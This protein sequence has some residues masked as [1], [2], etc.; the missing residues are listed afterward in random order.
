MAY[1]LLHNYKLDYKFINTWWISSV[2]ADGRTLTRGL[3]HAPDDHTN[4]YATSLD[5]NGKFDLLGFKHNLLLGVDYFDED[6]KQSLYSGLAPA[7]YRTIDMFAPVYVPIAVQQQPT[8]WAKTKAKWYG[9]YIQDQISLSPEWKLLVG[10][11]WDKPETWSGSS[12]VSYEGADAAF[13]RTTKNSVFNPRVGVVYQPQ[14]WLSLYGNYVESMGAANTGTTASGAAFDPQM[15]QQ[16]EV[17]L[18]AELLEK[19]LLANVALFDLTKQNLKTTDPA[20][21][22]F[23]IAVGEVR[24]R[25]L[26]IDLT[27]NITNALSVVATYAHLGSEITKDNGGN[28]GKRLYNTPKNS[29]SLWGKYAFGGDLYGLSAGA[30]VV[31]VGDHYGNN[32]NTTVVPGYTRTDAMLAYSWKSG[33]TKLTAQLNVENLFDKVYYSQGGYSGGESAYPGAP[34]TVTASI[35]ADF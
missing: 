25:G 7:A 5:L 12:T 6:T 14:P 1:R 10:G 17:G 30:G 3:Y 8:R 24:H 2:A 29:G 22:A 18:R 11:R 20:N 9:L 35:K 4:T 27:G 34:R 16:K 19:K 23:S 21:P 15:A 33:P 26:E 32:A 13:T 28:Q 31:V